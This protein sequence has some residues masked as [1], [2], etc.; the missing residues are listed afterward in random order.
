MT[1]LLCAAP[2]SAMAATLPIDGIH[3]NPAGCTLAATSN[4]GEDD[5]ARILKP[6]SLETM[7]TLCHFDTV[8]TGDRGAYLI[9]M[10]CAS[11]GSGPE[12]NY[13]DTAE[14][15][16]DT[17]SGYTVRFRDGTVWEPLKKC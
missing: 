7:V 17:K 14:I 13:Q 1:L 6:D 12:E 16:G 5:S 9:T 4:Y 10:T 8:E 2:L 11:E 3:G 15:T